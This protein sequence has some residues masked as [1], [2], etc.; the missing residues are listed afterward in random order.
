LIISEGFDIEHRMTRSLLALLLLSGC[1]HSVDGGPEVSDTRSLD[2]FSKV[3]VQD[4]L[5]VHFSPGAVNQVEL[6][7]QQKVLE[8]LQTTVSGGTLTVRLKPGVR[9]SSLE[10]TEVNVTGVDVRELNVSEGSGLIATNLKTDALTLAAS[11]GSRI[12][13]TGS[14]GALH[15]E[16]SGGSTVSATAQTADLDVSGGSEISLTAERIIGQASGG[17]R[18]AANA[19]ADLTGLIVSGG[20]QLTNN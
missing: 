16:A 18:I 7:T 1:Y 10:W 20:S 9:V 13:S 12:E 4:G 15:L 8:N 5:T 11:G 2:G 3:R 17:S 6:A 19:D 14:V